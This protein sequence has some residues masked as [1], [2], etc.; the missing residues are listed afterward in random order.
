MPKGGVLGIATRRSSN[1]TSEGIQVT[2]QDNGVGIQKENLARVFEPFFTT[3]G[4]LGTGIGLWVAKQL[5]ERHGG[6]ITLTSS[7]APIDSG[8]TVTVFFP[9][10][11][12]APSSEVTDQ[13][14]AKA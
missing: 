7:T 3:K 6:Q 1:Y 9:F 2:I 12:N 4:N 10:T 11:P 14:H 13:R 5:V 8:T